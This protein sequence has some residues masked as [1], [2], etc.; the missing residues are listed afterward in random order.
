MPRHNCFF[1]WQI[2]SEMSVVSSKIAKL[3][4]FFLKSKPAELVLYLEVSKIAKLCL[5]YQK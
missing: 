5:I 3:F 4:F 2:I 1:L